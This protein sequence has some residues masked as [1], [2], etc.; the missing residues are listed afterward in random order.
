MAAL[1]ASLDGETDAA[2]IQTVA[3]RMQAESAELQQMA[4]SFERQQQAKNAL[5]QRDEET[6]PDAEQLR[7]RART[8]DTVEML[9]A[10]IASASPE[11]VPANTPRPALRRHPAGP[12][13]ARVDP[14]HYRPYP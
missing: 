2:K 4:R 7:I 3:A 11:A 14:P 5:P 12:R 8:R 10:Q 13:S 9:L 1:A 6:A